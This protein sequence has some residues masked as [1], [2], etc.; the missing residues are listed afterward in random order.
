[1][2]ACTCPHCQT[3]LW[4]KDTQLNL[5]QGFVVC[6]QCEGLFKAAAHLADLG[7]H[8]QAEALP[9]AVTDVRLVHNIGA[10]VRQHKQLSR[11]EIA[12][13]LDGVTLAIKPEPAAKSG[14]NWR[15]ACAVAAAVLAIQ[16]V[17]LA[18]LA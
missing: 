11:N 10:Q 13:L 1:M 16:L 4:V 9:A 3:N 7:D 6:H 12:D 18:L 17:Y 15:T 2:P 8:F 5:A 14:F